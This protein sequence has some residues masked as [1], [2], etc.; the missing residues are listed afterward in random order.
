M[1]KKETYFK[2]LVQNGNKQLLN[3]LDLHWQTLKLI[4]NVWEMVA[5]WT[6][7]I[8]Q[9]LQV[10]SDKAFDNIWHL[11]VIAKCFLKQV[12][13]IYI[14]RKTWDRNAYHEFKETL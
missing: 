12:I 5:K 4:Y 14:A 10:A 11:T 13:E 8:T 3:A 7:E 2:I 9:L 1:N 6:L